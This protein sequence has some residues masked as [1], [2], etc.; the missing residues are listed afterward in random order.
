MSPASHDHEELEPVL[1]THSNTT[2]GRR[3]D[4]ALNDDERKNGS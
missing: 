4:A 3:P 2:A 1:S